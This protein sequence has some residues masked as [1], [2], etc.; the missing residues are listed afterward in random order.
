[1]PFFLFYFNIDIPNNTLF[2]KKRL[3]VNSI[4]ISNESSQRQKIVSESIYN[5]RE[6]IIFNLKNLF[7]DQFNTSNKK[8]ASGISKNQFLSSVQKFSRNTSI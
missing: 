4:I 2:F 7:L 8:L 1:M 5:F 6:T 3:K